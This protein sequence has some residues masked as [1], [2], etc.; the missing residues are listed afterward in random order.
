M[1][2]LDEWDVSRIAM[3]IKG[4]FPFLADAA[5]KATTPQSCGATLGGAWQWMPLHGCINF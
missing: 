2:Y 5:P 4:L 1:N 3:G